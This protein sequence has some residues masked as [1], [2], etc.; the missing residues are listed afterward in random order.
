MRQTIG[1]GKRDRYHR[2]LRQSGAAGGEQPSVSAPGTVACWETACVSGG[3]AS[4]PPRCG[5]CRDLGLGPVQPRPGEG[6][7]EGACAAQSS[8]LCWSRARPAAAVSRRRL[9]GR[10]SAHTAVIGTDTQ[11]IWTRIKR[12]KTAFLVLG[13][14]RKV[15]AD[16]VR[17]TSIE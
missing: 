5:G 13:I 16:A 8:P 6:E 12:C 7:G 11:A 2:S 1:D 15:S 17:Y 3:T 9:S 10:Q 4:P 14:G